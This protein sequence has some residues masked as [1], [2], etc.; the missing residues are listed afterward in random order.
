MNLV[1]FVASRAVD[2]ANF[3]H[4]PRTVECVLISLTIADF[5]MCVSVLFSEF[6][7]CYD[8]R[9]IC[10]FPFHLNYYLFC[11]LLMRAALD[12]IQFVI[13]VSEMC[14]FVCGFSQQW[15]PFIHLSSRRHTAAAEC[16]V[17]RRL[18]PWRDVGGCVLVCTSARARAKR[19]W[20]EDDDTARCRRRRKEI[21]FICAT[22]NFCVFLHFSVRF[23]Y[24]F[25][26]WYFGLYLLFST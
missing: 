11:R 8:V 4:V 6:Y 23:R 7:D 3:V 19:K 5:S 26:S 15:R 22:V 13:P 10:L 1:F 14:A 20:E 25:N 18:L 21:Y 24:A 16:E 2:S 17:F 12:A 9:H